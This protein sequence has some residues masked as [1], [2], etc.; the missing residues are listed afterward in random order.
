MKMLPLMFIYRF[1]S[2]LIVLFIVLSVFFF[3]A[4]SLLAKIYL[5]SLILLLLLIRLVVTTTMQDTSAIYTKSLLGLVLL[6]YLYLNSNIA[7]IPFEAKVEYLNFNLYIATFLLFSLLQA[8]GLNR[9]IKISFLIITTVLFLLRI[10][11]G[12]KIVYFFVYNPNILAGTCLAI[13]LYIV[14]DVVEKKEIGFTE[15]TILFMS[16]LLLILSGSYSSIFIMIALFLYSIFKTKHLA[17][18]VIVSIA[19][20]GIFLNFTSVVDRLIWNVIGIKVWLR[21]IFFGV[22]LGN[23]KFLYPTYLKDINVLPST[24][25]IFVHNYFINLLSEIGF[26]GI[27][28]FLL[29]V[30]A[31]LKQ[32]DRDYAYIYPVYGM[33]AHNLVDYNLLI[34]QNGILFFMFLG[35]K[36]W[37]TQ[38]FSRNGGTKRFFNTICFL[39]IL[40]TI[41]GLF[42]CFKLQKIFNII[43]SDKIEEIKKIVS[44]DET[45]WYAWKKLAIK[46]MVSGNTV[47]AE[48]MFIKTIQTNPYE[49][50]SYFYLAVISFKNGYRQKAYQYLKTVVLL[51]P[52]LSGRYIRMFKNFVINTN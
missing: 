2:V 50:D 45:C 44:S 37:K 21:N 11:L 1:E 34:P 30:Y 12:E 49:A 20:I 13:T 33:L 6:S 28:I 46:A 47:E 29:L 18:L 48:D 27:L 9:E 23:F 42:S 17:I 8:R 16:V 39:G 25:T 51:Q 32:R 5:F 26:V 24:A 7:K 31:V 14:G 3:S 36:T 22:G 38:F 4:V 43:S 40:I 10:L 52:R 35:L 41:F 19:I 15:I